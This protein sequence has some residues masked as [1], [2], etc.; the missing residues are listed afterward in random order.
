MPV[1]Y[2]ALS[3]K[4]VLAAIVALHFVMLLGWQ[5]TRPAAPPNQPGK[6]MQVVW[7]APVRMQPAPETE[8]APPPTRPQSRPT[9]ASPQQAARP[10]V[11]PQAITLPPPAAAPAPS[12]GDDPFAAPPAAAPDVASAARQAAGKIDK[13]LREERLKGPQREQI[14]ASQQRFSEE[15]E[16][17][18]IGAGTV[19][20]Q[21][22]ANGDRIDKVRTPFGTYCM[23]SVSPRAGIDGYE[24][25]RNSPTMRR[26]D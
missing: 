13:Q 24:R 12:L 26:C 1:D 9:R 16:A 4:P 18:L 5:A 22:S 7:I 25:A 2:P 21:R 23:R 14:L 6:D 19:S 3:R 17:R 10:R 15:Q 20:S 11:E 8:S